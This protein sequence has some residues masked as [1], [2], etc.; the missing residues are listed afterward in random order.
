MRMIQTVKET[1]NEAMKSS[2]FDFIRLSFD[3]YREMEIGAND[4]SK[5]HS[6]LV[7]AGIASAILFFIIEGIV[8]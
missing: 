5:A 2:E 7:G 6:I 4:V 3:G 8:L 1:E